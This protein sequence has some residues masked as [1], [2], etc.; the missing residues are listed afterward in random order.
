MVLQ[1][2]LGAD[3][4]RV[5]GGH[6][7]ARGGLWEEPGAQRFIGALAMKIVASPYAPGDKV[8]KQG[9]DAT[10]MFI[11]SKGDATVIAAEKEIATIGDCCICCASALFREGNYAYTVQMVSMLFCL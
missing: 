9:A 4:A 7:A 5:A 11:F 10:S 3:A 2:G 1:P 6:G 8:C